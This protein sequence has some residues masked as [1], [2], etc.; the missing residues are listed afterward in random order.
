MITIYFANDLS[1]EAGRKIAEILGFWG[2]GTAYNYAHQGNYNL[3]YIPGEKHLWWREYPYLKSLENV[4]SRHQNC[5]LTSFLR[6][7]K[8]PSLF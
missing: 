5:S 2:C 7:A 4:E 6:L 8:M 3:Y 1:L